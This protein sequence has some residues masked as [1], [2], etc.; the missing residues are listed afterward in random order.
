MS[1]D[2]Q[3][4]ES[5]IRFIERSAG[6]QPGL[7]D[8]A[9]AVGLSPYHLQRLFRRWAG[10]SPKRFLQHLTVEHAKHALARSASV[11][12][13]TYEAGLSGPGRLH[14]HFVSLEAVTPGEYG[15]RGA[16]LRIRHGTHPGPFGPMLV[17]VT[18]RGVCRLAF[19]DGDGADAAT[20]ELETLRRDW[21]A[22]GIVEDHGGT[23]AVAAR[24]FAEAAPD[25]APITLAVKGTNFQVNVWKALLRIPPGGLR[26]Y[27]Q[28]ARAVGRP[29]AARAVGR[30]VGANPVAWLIPCHRVI[31]AA[32]RCG[33]YR[34]GA[35]RKR[36]L[37]AWEA[38]R[39]H[40][41]SAAVPA[42]GGA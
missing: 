35:T 23:G 37:I 18:D 9:A 19:L 4:V 31:R 27:E 28:V 10:I 22:A 1:T 14:D 12:D 36:A 2:Y 17:A 33:D 7:E 5:A 38:A 39:A 30:A 8:V 15:R 11:L 21:P 3:R 29:S 13:A 25:A 32:G 40:A 24:L 16:G 20:A 42:L 41:G 6:G 26:S 34:W